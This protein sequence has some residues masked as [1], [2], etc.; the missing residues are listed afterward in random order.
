MAK[1]LGWNG[2]DG[3]GRKL[4]EQT[5]LDTPV[6]PAVKV[7]GLCRLLRIRCPLDL[8]S[9]KGA[10]RVEGKPLSGPPGEYGRK[11]ETNPF[12][13]GADASTKKA[14]TERK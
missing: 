5:G 2:S 3:E 12:F 14:F 13:P 7:D 6:V 9:L 8:G 1:A 11:A 4:G 10:A